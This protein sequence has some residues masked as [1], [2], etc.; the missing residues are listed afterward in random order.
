M[1]AMELFLRA[2]NLSLVR[3]SRES[4]NPGLSYP[5]DFRAFAGMTESHWF[6][7]H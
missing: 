4:G 7:V 2:L 3:H 6:A 1:V 5:L